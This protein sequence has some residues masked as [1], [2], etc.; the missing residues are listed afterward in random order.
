MINK[1]FKTV[2]LAAVLASGGTAECEAAI[3]TFDFGPTGGL[4][5]GELDGLSSGSSTVS[6]I[7]MTA[8]ALPGGTKF[9][10][11][12]TGFGI[13]V[14]SNAGDDSD[15]FDGGISAESMVFSFSTAGTLKLI[16]FDRFSGSTTDDRV[17]V[18]ISG[19][20]SQTLTDSDLGTD[21][22]F[23]FDSSWA[24]GAG[25]ELTIAFVN[26]NG[27][28]LDSIQINTFSAVPEPE[29]Y[30]LFSG[31]ALVGFAAWRKRKQA[32]AA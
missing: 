21:N 2:L 8:S 20:N 32:A 6:G 30:A 5:G 18:S 25:T 16:S 1:M 12:A 24:F 9:N 23:D 19:G 22:A 15:A 13:D 17:S 27:F 31:L 3:V 4:S 7:I 11:T 14:P 28:G 26:G 29:T 10:Q